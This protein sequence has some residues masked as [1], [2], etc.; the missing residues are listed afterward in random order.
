MGW[1]SFQPKM[2]KGKEAKGREKAGVFLFCRVW[3]GL[4]PFF[5]EKTGGGW[6]KEG[7]FVFQLSRRVSLNRSEMQCC[8][9]YWAV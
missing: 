9:F 4:V 6:M 7:F 3:V 2:R 5:R 8:H 1:F